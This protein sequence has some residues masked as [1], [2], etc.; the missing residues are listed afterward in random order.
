MKRISLLALLMG[1][2]CFSVPTFAANGE[3]SPLTSASPVA[4]DATFTKEFSVSDFEQ[5]QIG[6][7]FI[8][9]VRP[10]DTF[11]VTVTGQ[12][13]D[14]ENVE[15]EVR[16]NELTLSFTDKKMRIGSR[17]KPRVEIQMPNLRA[18][19]FSGT[20]KSVIH[21]GFSPGNFVAYLSGSADA[22]I[23]IESREMYLD[24]SGT[25]SLA[26]KGSA[27]QLKVNTSGAASLNAF[28]LLA[29]EAQ[30]DVSGT[31]GARVNVKNTIKASASGAGSIRYKGEAKLNSVSASRMSSIKKVEG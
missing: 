22:E 19:R 4:D 14:V 10:G 9:H 24:L 30:L 12:K 31:S 6:A 11:K 3:K 8:V 25:S 1:A 13:E 23:E 27:G 20:S 2:V 17:Q 7:V 21:P 28:D 16:N 5:L 15:A 18:V 26:I 29:T